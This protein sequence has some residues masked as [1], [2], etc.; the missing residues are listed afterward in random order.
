MPSSTVGVVRDREE[1][2]KWR[3]VWAEETGREKDDPGEWAGDLW[4]P[5]PLMRQLLVV[6][7]DGTGQL[8]TGEET[9]EEPQIVERLQH[10]QRESLLWKPLSPLH[11][12]L[13][14]YC[15]RGT[16]ISSNCH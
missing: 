4:G 3:D 11:T 16:R 1:P 10:V 9:K 7:E 6:K 13:S 12:P 15:R 8:E 14:P 2:E 5:V